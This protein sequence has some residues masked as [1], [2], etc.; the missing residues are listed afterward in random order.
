M[1][2]LLLLGLSAVLCIACGPTEGPDSCGPCSGCCSQGVCVAGDQ[3][4]A[5]GVGVCQ[6]CA[7]TEQCIAGSCSAPVLTGTWVKADLGRDPALMSSV[8][9]TSPSDVWATGSDRQVLHFDGSAWT[10]SLRVGLNNFSAVWASSSQDVWV[11][12]DFGDLRHWDGTQWSDNL[13]VDRRGLTALSGTSARDVWAVGQAGLILRWNGT[14]WSPITNPGI[15]SNTWFDAVWAGPGNL[16][17]VGGG[18]GDNI[19]LR[20]GAWNSQLGNTHSISGLWAASATDAWAATGFGLLHWDGRDWLSATLPPMPSV[21]LGN[22]VS[23]SGSVNAVWGSASN[24]VWA[25]GAMGTVFHWNGSHWETAHLPNTGVFLNSVGG[26]SGRD[27]WVVGW[28]TVA[29]EGVI[30][31]WQPGN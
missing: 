18:G 31:H 9:A 5:C 30:F 15:A 16:V 20:N 8:W 12:G 28:D 6:A 14:A 22:G 29:K 10:T 25:V 17:W 19:M 13:G 3:Q 2:R 21:Y 11:A 7:G 23:S 27:V 26:T 4:N 1:R 24:D